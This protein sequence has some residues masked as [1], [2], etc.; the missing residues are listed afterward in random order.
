MELVLVSRPATAVM[1][2][3]HRNHQRTTSAFVSWF[4]EDAG[5]WRV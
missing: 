4:H 2:P 5:R 1:A 3:F